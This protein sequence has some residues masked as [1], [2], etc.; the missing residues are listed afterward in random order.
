MRGREQAGRTQ[1]AQHFL[2]VLGTPRL[3]HELQFGV[4]HRQRREGALVLDFLDVG[5]GLADQRGRAREFAGNVAGV[6]AD[7][8][9]ARN[10]IAPL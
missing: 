3:Q 10:R 7:A 6:Y 5:A 4:L 8:R 1:R 9:E 2:D